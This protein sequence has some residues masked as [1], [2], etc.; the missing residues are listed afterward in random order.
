MP[1]RGE[2]IK[3]DKYNQRYH[4]IT[5]NEKST[6]EAGRR[7]Q[8]QKHEEEGKEERGWKEEG[9]KGKEETTSPGTHGIWW[10]PGGGRTDTKGPR[11]KGTEGKAGTKMGMEIPAKAEPWRLEVTCGQATYSIRLHQDV[12]AGEVVS[13]L[14]ALSACP[15]EELYLTETGGEPAGRRLGKDE[16]VR[17]NQTGLTL[18]ENDKG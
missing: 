9:K 12:R 3:R 10:R 4:G 2:A 6:G 18:G 5:G 14:G 17:N 16:V 15:T 11:M 1:T 7:D 8:N 13:I